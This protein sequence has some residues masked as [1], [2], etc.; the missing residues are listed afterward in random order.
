MPYKFDRTFFEEVIM[1][2]ALG[3]VFVLALVIPS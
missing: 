2:S 1:L 3:L